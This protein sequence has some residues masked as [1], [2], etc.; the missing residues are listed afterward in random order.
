MAIASHAFAECCSGLQGLNGR[1][2]RLFLRYPWT[3]SGNLPVQENTSGDQQ[4]CSA[5]CYR[6]FSFRKRH[7]ERLYVVRFRQSGVWTVGTLVRSHLDRLAMCMAPAFRGLRDLFA[8]AKAVRQA[9]SGPHRDFVPIARLIAERSG[10]A[11][12]ARLEHFPIQAHPGHHAVLGG[13]SEQRLVVTMAV[14]DCS[15]LQL[16]RVIIATLEEVGHHSWKAFWT[17]AFLVTPPDS[18]CFSAAERETS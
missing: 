12:T 9:L 16:R 2:S 1:G 13:H 5:G 18:R 8:T 10:H 3:L 4:S 11:A 17:G 14:H 7:R 6:L 15:A